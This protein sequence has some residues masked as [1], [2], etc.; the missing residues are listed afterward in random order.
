MLPASVGGWC[1]AHYAVGINTAGRSRWWYRSCRAAVLSGG[2]H[3]GCAVRTTGP[4][5][6]GP[7]S[8]VEPHTWESRG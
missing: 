4:Y 3:G 6:A 7:A 2:P 5:V 8:A 1:Q